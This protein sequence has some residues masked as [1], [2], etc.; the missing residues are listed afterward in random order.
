MVRMEEAWEDRL[1]GEEGVEERS[2]VVVVLG[3]VVLGA[4]NAVT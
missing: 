3:V 2:S 4:P 1:R